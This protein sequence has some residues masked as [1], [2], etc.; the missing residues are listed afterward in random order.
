M[1]RWFGILIPFIVLG[2]LIGWRLNQ[3]RAENAAQASQQQA[4]MKAIPSVVTAPVQLRDIIH[5]FEATGSVD[6]PLSVKIA[7]KVTG[8]IDYLEVHEGD[9]VRKGQVLV[10]IDPSEVE[11]NVRQAQAAF[12][13]AKYR[14]A[15][16]QLGQNPNNVSIATQIRQQK[17]GVASATADYNQVR[18]SY[19]SQVAT[20]EADVTDAQ[21][22]IDSAN[23]AIDNAKSAVLS[24]QANLDNANA[25]YER[26]LGL[27]KQGFIAAQDVDDAK[28]AVS[29]QQAAFEVASGQVKSVVAQKN[30]AVAQKKAAEHQASIVA[31]KGKADIEAAHAKLLQAQ[32]S[33]ESA[34]ANTA[35]KSAYEQSLAALRSSVAAAEA[36]LRSAEARRA[37]TKLI[38]PLD[39]FVTNRYLDPGS[40]AGPSQP[41]LGVQFVKQIWVTISVPEEISTR[42]HIG[43]SARIK[44]DALPGRSFT[45]SI[46]QINPSADP[47]NR[48]FT[49]RVV[50]SNADDL[51]KPG[52]FARVSVETDHIKN[53]M[54]VPREAVKQDRNG[55]YIMVVG[56]DGTVQHRPIISGAEDTGYIAITQGVKPGEKVIIMST[57]QI[58]DGQKV[59]TGGGPGKGP[60]RGGRP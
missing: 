57:M 17:A 54:A 22:K 12:A 51:L 31:R 36:S 58:R 3:K 10:R 8:R 6:A 50:L 20:A 59:R 35:Q 40:I 19:E 46:I 42:L 53:A 60:G 56:G 52:M 49:V 24:A 39:G 32:A 18:E 4:R 48:Q 45:G 2:S 33:L 37:D 5:T 15:Q 34:S 44:V 14:L 30:S 27:Y 28:T 23:A 11:A 16:A 25:K 43:Q 7:P 1:K 38:S 55:T 47:E 41:V 29:V 13:E 9:H 26:I 21:G